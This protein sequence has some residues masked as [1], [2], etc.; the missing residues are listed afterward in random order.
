MAKIKIIL[1]GCGI[2]Y[3]DEHGTKRHALKTPEDGA[4][5][6]DDAQAERLVSLKVAV[7]V[8]EKAT[9]SAPQT[10]AQTET[11]KA[12]QETEQETEQTTGHLDAEELAKMDYN[13]LKAL[14]AEMGVTPAGKKKSDYIAAIVAA[15]VEVDDEDDDNELPELSAADPE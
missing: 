8:E 6:C 5:E 13:A 15:E 3:T 14:A 9:E 7:Y 10:D 1:G 2:N 11:V 12:P 4:F